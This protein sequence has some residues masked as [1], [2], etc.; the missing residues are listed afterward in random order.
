MKG[1]LADNFDIHL[2]AIADK[3]PQLILGTEPMIQFTEVG[4]AEPMSVR[5]L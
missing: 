4:W 3:T 5:I 1:D 2:P